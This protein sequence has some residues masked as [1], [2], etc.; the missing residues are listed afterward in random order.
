MRAMTVR[1]LNRESDASIFPEPLLLRFNPRQEIKGDL[2][3]FLGKKKKVLFALAVSQ[4]NTPCILEASKN[5][6]Q[7]SEELETSVVCVNVY[8]N[9]VCMSVSTKRRPTFENLAPRR[10]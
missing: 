7:F 9:G 10:C 5:K 2:C 4:K 8:L 6:S 3:N 1:L